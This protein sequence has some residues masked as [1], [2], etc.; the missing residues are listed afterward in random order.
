MMNE[1]LKKQDKIS[2]QTKKTYLQTASTLPFNITTTQATI[3]KKLKSLYDNPNTLSL[4]L[5]MIIL[6][7]RDKDLEHDKLIKFRNELR[8]K[9][10][11]VRKSNM[12]DTKNTLITYNE[13]LDKLNELNG[14]RYVLN[15]LLITFGFR[16]KDIN[17]F[18]VEKL[19]TEINEETNYIIK[20]KSGYKLNINDYKT[21]SSFGTKTINITDSKFK[22]EMKKL[23]FKDNSYILPKK[24]GDKLK[25]NSFNDKVISLTIDGLGETKIFK[26]IIKHLL[27]SKDFTKLEELVNTRGTSLATILKSYNVYNNDM[28]KDEKKTDEIKEEIKD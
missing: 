26:I 3:I 1:Y 9:I 19:P 7:R 23:N 13:L 28:K 4:Y 11:E 20:S 10:I 24:N 8:E 17:L 6:L 12:S 2:T 15:Y 16:N 14:I 27:D 21:E 18:Y 22:T 25:L 5:N